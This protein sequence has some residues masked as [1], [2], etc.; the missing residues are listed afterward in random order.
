[1]LGLTTTT[2]MQ[3]AL[4]AT[5][6]SE[7]MEAYNKADVGGQTVTGSRWSGMCVS[8]CR[9]MKNVAMPELQHR[10]GGLKHIVFAEIDADAKPELCRKILCGTLHT[11][12]CVVY[13]SRAKLWRRT[14]LTGAHSPAEIRRKF[15][16]RQIAAG[17]TVDPN[18]RA[19]EEEGRAARNVVARIGP[20]VGVA[21]PA[22]NRCSWIGST[23]A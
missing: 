4:L 18:E 11:T 5:A 12:T 16:K 6:G 9:V 22:G 3:F 17:R 10:R 14:Q 1:M 8:G 7:Y 23:D 20:P 13:A 2:V 19:R 15:L 21:W